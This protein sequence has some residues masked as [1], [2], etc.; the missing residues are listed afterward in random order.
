M[1]LNILHLNQGDSQNDVANKLNQNFQQITSFDGGPYG[2]KGQEG[3]PGPTGALGITGSY[4]DQGLRGTK[5]YVQQDEP[6][7]EPFFEGDSW[8]N[9][10][11]NGL[12]FTYT[13]GS[14]VASGYN[15][16]REGIFRVSPR[17]IGSGSLPNNAYVQSSQ[18]PQNNTL[19]ISSTDPSSVKNPQFSKINIGNIGSNDT[20]LIE[21]SKGDY[22]GIGTYST[23]S[24]RIRWSSTS[25]T[26][27]PYGLKLD[28]R[29]GIVIYSPRVS[30][31]SYS[32]TS[33]SYIYARSNVSVSTSSGINV[34]PAEDL[35]ILTS[36]NLSFSS[37]NI[38]QW[39]STGL[40]SSSSI[41]TNQ[42]AG[43]TPSLQVSSGLT[44]NRTLNSDYTKNIILVRNSTTAASYPI[45]SNY[46]DG[47]IKVDKKISSYFSGATGASGPG[48]FTFADGDVVPSGDVWVLTPTF[49]TLTGSSSNLVLRYSIGDDYFFNANTTN[50]NNCLVLWLPGP[51][52]GSLRK[53]FVDLLKENNSSITFRV[54]INVTGTASSYGFNFI[55]ID[56]NYTTPTTGNLNAFA[57]TINF[58]GTG[59]PSA[60]G[61]N[62]GAT[63]F[64]IT[65]VSVQT[66][67]TSG[68]VNPWYRVYW[69]AW[70]GY[71]QNQNSYPRFS[72]GVL[73]PN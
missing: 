10:S 23:G 51:T 24:P 48:K 45:F 13:S 54:H 40:T 62:N 8:I 50:P 7:S 69:K 17:N 32:T 61:S 72:C 14:W 29:S 68:T 67:G 70:G 59:D 4:G 56:S 9:T 20:P 41:E 2:K 3:L 57:P 73:Y 63:D 35:F 26:T 43:S 27:N 46:G 37:Q 36:G 55:G 21:F 44:L 58:V 5:W 15:I 30:L 6:S 49:T 1:D 42:T 25:T 11:R 16:Y 12:V 60:Y 31:N 66:P 52:S 65:I 39:N 34:T 38:Q 53:G 28:F 71:L 19:V 47:S 64:E 22:Q 33:E 18:F